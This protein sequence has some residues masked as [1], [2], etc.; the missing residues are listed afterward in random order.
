MCEKRTAVKVRFDVFVD[1]LSNTSVIRA[2]VKAKH[3]DDALITLLRP[4]MNRD[5]AGAHLVD[6]LW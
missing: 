2:V 5:S 6:D 3:T 1:S 4:T